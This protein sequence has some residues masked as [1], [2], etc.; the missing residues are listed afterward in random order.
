MIQKILNILIMHSHKPKLELQRPKT[1]A[2]YRAI[3]Y[4]YV[5]V[6]NYDINTLLLKIAR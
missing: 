2:I 4:N 5:F 1:C 6:S 3:S